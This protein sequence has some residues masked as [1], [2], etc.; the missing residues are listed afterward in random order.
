MLLLPDCCITGS[1]SIDPRLL[2]SPTAQYYY[3]LLN[4]QIKPWLYCCIRGACR[5]IKPPVCKK[6]YTNQINI[7]P[8]MVSNS[9]GI[10]TTPPLFRRNAPS[11]WP[12]ALREKNS[13]ATPVYR[14]QYYCSRL[15]LMTDR[16]FRIAMLD[17]P[18]SVSKTTGDRL[19]YYRTISSGKQRWTADMIFADS[20]CL[21]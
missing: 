19:Q 3:P 16:N 15:N 8:G 2:D 20:I 11:R 6:N 1:C 12:Q 9:C 4:Y 7:I 10:A 13:V 21:N 5:Y 17:E 18:L 14:L